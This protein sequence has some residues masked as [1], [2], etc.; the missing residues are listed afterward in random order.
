[1]FTLFVMFQLF[2]AFNCREL[3]NES[4]FPRLFKNRLML[5]AFVVAFALQVLITQFGGAVFDTV[6]LDVLS[7]LKVVGVALSV[8]VL[9]ELVRLV[10]RAARRKAGK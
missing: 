7:W 3:G 4:I 10:R 2:N 6:P 5:I 1:M 9:D 8:I